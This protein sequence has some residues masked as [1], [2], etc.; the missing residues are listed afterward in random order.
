MT[1]ICSVVLSRR[2]VDDS[3]AVMEAKHVAPFRDPMINVVAKW[4][5]ALA[6]SASMRINNKLA[7]YPFV[8]RV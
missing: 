4:G 5:Y 8:A 7:A 3:L 6:Y 1:S 2:M